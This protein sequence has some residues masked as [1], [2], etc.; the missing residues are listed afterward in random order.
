MMI[1]HPDRPRESF[2]EMPETPIDMKRYAGACTE[3]VEVDRIAEL[4]TECDP[5]L[6]DIGLIR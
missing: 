3:S 2:R 4:Q 5:V 1:A 6:V